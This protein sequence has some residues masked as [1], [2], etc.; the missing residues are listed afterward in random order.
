MHWLRNM[1]PI[2]PPSLPIRYVLVPVF[3]SLTGYTLG[4][5]ENKIRKGVW[6]EGHEYRRAPDGHV[7][8]DLRGY[9]RWVEHHEQA[10]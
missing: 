4:A 7:L 1:P 3:C 9:E 8:V 6:R 5:V 10:A 2:A